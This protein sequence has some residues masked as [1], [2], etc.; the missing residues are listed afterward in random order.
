MVTYTRNLCS[1]FNPSKVHTHSSE[2]THHEHTPGAVG[3]H[4]CC[5]TQGAVLR[6]L[7][8]LSVPSQNFC[9]LLQRYLHLLAKPVEFG[10]TY[11]LLYGLQWLQLCMFT[12][13][14]FIE[15][16][17]ELGLKDKKYSQ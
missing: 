13:E 8:K 16:Y 14:L 6:S 15:F 4:L 12:M 10:Q 5:G 3:S 7:E 9:V 17:F 2:H 1:A 11:C